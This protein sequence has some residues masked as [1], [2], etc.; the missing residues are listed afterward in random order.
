M[1]GL[2]FGYANAGQVGVP[3]IIQALLAGG[4]AGGV[5]VY[6]GDA[7]VK[8]TKSTLTAN[9]VPV[10]RTLLAA[11]V[12]ATYQQGGSIAGIWGMACEDVTTNSSG[13][14]IQSPTLG[15]IATGG[16]VIYPYSYDGLQAVD[17]NTVRSYTR[18]IQATGN[19]VFAAK[20]TAASAVGT[21]A[22]IT[23]NAALTLTGTAP[24]TF[25][26]DTTGGST[27]C[28]QIVGINTSDPN[29]GAHGC[30]VFF[31]ILPTY[32]QGDTGVLYTSN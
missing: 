7:V 11:D 9:V 13:Q 22:L 8:T 29:Y 28:I 31:V 2:R 30:E 10:I 21:P 6:S 17:S 14:A 32:R 26:V 15:N 20:L 12:T 18:V 4:S 24:T 27:N 23:T 16:S 3:F 5:T 19:M 1:P 25:T